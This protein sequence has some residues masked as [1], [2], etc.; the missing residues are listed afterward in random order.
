MQL[1]TFVGPT[2]ALRPIAQTQRAADPAVCPSKRSPHARSPRSRHRAPPEGH[3]P[4]LAGAH[5]LRRLLRLPGVAALAPVVLDPRL[6]GLRGEPEDART[7][8]DRRSAPER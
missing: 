3:H 5:H 2:I 6:P 1:P 7:V 8:R 4:D